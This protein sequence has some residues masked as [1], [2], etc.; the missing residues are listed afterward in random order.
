MPSSTDRRSLL[1]SAAALLGASLVPGVA[2]A[3][4]LRTSAPQPFSFDIL[5]DMARARHVFQNVEGEGLRRGRAQALSGGDAGNQRCA[6][7]RGCGGE[8]APAVGR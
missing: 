3:Q 6:E 5:K 1:A 4:G 7:K 8:Q 2:A